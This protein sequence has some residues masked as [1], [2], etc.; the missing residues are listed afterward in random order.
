MG[1]VQVGAMFLV[2]LLSVAIQL[3]HAGPSKDQIAFLATYA[4]LNPPDSPHKPV[5]PPEKTCGSEHMDDLSHCTVL[6]LNSSYSPTQLPA[7]PAESVE[8]RLP[9]GGTVS[10]NFAAELG[11]KLDELVEKLEAHPSIDTLVL[12]S[13][14]MHEEGAARFAK[15]LAANRTKLHSLALSGCLIGDEGAVQLAAAIRA[16]GINRLVVTHDRT[17][18]DTGIDALVSIQDVLIVFNGITL[19]S[20]KLDISKRRDFTLAEAKMVR[21]AVKAGRIKELL[22][23]KH[24]SR[25]DIVAALGMADKKAEL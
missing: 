16:S 18:G 1:S 17:V 21:A 19:H 12:Q 7:K 8:V 23:G 5:A 20:D 15:S 10:R 24:Y 4:Q 14:Y 13:L 22:L 3:S 25:P 9:G 11:S 6:R 2:L